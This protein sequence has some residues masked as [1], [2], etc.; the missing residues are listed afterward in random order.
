MFVHKPRKDAFA[1]CSRNALRVRGARFLLNAVWVAPRRSVKLYIAK[2]SGNH[3][4]NT[5]SITHV[6]LTHG[7]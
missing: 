2:L 1:N 4:S 5:V 6:F 3:L 7:K